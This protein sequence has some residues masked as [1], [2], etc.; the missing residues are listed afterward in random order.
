MP[1]QP[2]LSG[3]ILKIFGKEREPHMGDLVFYGGLDICLEIMG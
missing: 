1:H 2:L 3:E